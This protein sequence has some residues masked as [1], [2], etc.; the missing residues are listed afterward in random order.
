LAQQAYYEYVERLFYLVESGVSETE[1]ALPHLH[2]AE[3]STLFLDEREALAEVIDRDASL[4]PRAQEILDSV[5][6]LITQ[7]NEYQEDR[8]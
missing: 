4:A 8:A 7:I 2:I 5:L 1:E 6:R 3:P